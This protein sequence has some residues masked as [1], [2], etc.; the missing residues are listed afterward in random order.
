MLNKKLLLLIIISF[1]AF[2]SS[3]AQDKDSTKT[4]WDDW[5]HHK[6]NFHFH[7][8][9]GRPTASFTYGIS[10]MN[11]NSL[12][13]SLA[14]PGLAE[15][16]LGYTD[17]K[18]RIGDTEGISRYRFRYAFFSNVSAELT[19]SGS[20]TDLRTDMWR[21]GFGRASGYGYNFGSSS[22][23]PYYGYSFGWSKLRLEDAP[24]NAIDTSLLDPFKNTFRFGT[25]ME[26]GIRFKV[27]SHFVVDAGYER[28][29]IFPRHLFWKWAG[30]A[31]I[32][33]GGQLAVNKFVDEILK[34]SPYAA[35]VMNFVLK[36][37]LSYGIYELRRD[38][39]NWP[40]DSAAPLAYD[41]FKVGLTFVF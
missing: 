12:T 22:I 23:I 21:F 8:F 28:S 24:V 5:K 20:A 9:E 15:L 11:L 16:R 17:E 38:K 6:F 34:S 36:T 29:I 30:S 40:F 3:F 39:M 41:Q 14:K 26:G 35:P 18:P 25:S 13:G 31:V 7:E 27:F 4:K 1:F 33:A 32:E 2:A 37:A 10:N 19:K